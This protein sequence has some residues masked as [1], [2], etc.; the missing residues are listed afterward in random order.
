VLGISQI[1]VANHH[2]KVLLVIGRFMAHMFA[3]ET[4]ADYEH[5]FKRISK[6]IIH[7]ITSKEILYDV[8][9]ASAVGVFFW[10]IF[11]VLRS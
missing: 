4:T 8:I 6:S 3:D 11:L 7:G 1:E 10:F 9:Y 5:I 2:E